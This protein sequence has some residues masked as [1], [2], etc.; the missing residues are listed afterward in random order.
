VSHR[1]NQAIFFFN[2]GRYFEAHE[3]WEEMWREEQ[4]N[5]RLFYQGLVQASVGLHHLARKNLVGARLQLSKALAKLGSYPPEIEGINLAELRRDLR[6]VLDE[7][8]A[9]HTSRAIRPANIRIANL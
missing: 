8:E 4:G 3:V 6:R 5:L 1:L 7:L 2:S 9:P